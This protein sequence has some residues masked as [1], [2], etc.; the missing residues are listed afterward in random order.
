ML[1]RFGPRL[2]NDTAS[3]SHKQRD[4]AVG[5]RIVRRARTTLV[6]IVASVG[7]PL[8]HEAAQIAGGFLLLNKVPIS[9]RDKMT[10][11]VKW[12]KLI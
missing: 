4:D 12:I 10:G 6:A 7:P 2:Q 11:F 8:R 1:D 3:L 5:L 9:L